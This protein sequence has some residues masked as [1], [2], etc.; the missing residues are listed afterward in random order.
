MRR[1]C[2]SLRR[3]VRQRRLSPAAAERDNEGHHLSLK[4]P[5]S[6]QQSLFD[7]QLLFL[8]GDDGGEGLGPRLIF[9][10]RDLRR[11]SGDATV[12]GLHLD[13]ARQD[14]NASER[15]LDLLDRRQ[16]RLAIDRDIGLIGLARRLDLSGGKAAVEQ[17]LRKRGA[18][19]PD[20]IAR[21]ELGGEWIAGK[22]DQAVERDGRKIARKL[23]PDLGVGLAHGLLGRRHVGPSLQERRRQRD[24][25]RWNAR[26]QRA[27]WDRKASRRAA[28][29]D[30]D[31][32]FGR[33]ARH[34]GGDERRLSV[35]HL[36]FGGD[37]V[38]LGGGPGVILVLGDRQRM[39]EFDNSPVEQV[40]ERIILSQRHI[41]E[42][43]HRL[44]GKRGVGEIDGIR[45]C[46]RLLRFWLPPDLTPDVERPRPRGFGRERRD[47]GR[48]ARRGAGPIDG[49]K[50]PGPR[51]VDERQRLAIIGLVRL[52]RLVGH[53]DD[54]YE[55]VKFRIMKNRPPGAFGLALARRRDLP[56]LDL[57]ELGGH[58][59]RR[60]LEVGT[61]RHAS[62]DRKSGD[63][64][65]RARKRQEFERASV[66]RRAPPTDGRGHCLDSRRL[67]YPYSCPRYAGQVVNAQSDSEAP[68]PGR[69]A[70]PNLLSATL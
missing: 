27:M 59:R 10:K 48:G 53:D 65:R 16:H 11:L 1:N 36:R 60:P 15:V 35:E 40:L 7:R 24:R 33:G 32:I 8:G 18:E 66:R 56:A 57:L 19:R 61:D 37:H 3:Y 4:L 13:L 67:A 51:L 21:T 12:I 58:D 46:D 20:R 63:K 39:F 55:L 31:R 6:R 54:S 34:G 22:T 28:H 50:E 70:S 5:L 17:R 29:R 41:S 2:R 43:Q 52:D 45:L 14:A 42:R 26:P 9:V 49:R 44:L 68:P 69:L 38:R 64:R 62:G 25:K 47:G 23:D 30:R